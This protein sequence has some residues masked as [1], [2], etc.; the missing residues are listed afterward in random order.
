MATTPPVTPAPIHPSWFSKALTWVKHEASVVKNSVLWLANKE[1]AVA[2][3]IQK[4]AP[5]VEELSN[6]FVPG[7]GNIEQHVVD[8]YGVVASAVHAAGDAAAAN[9]VSV[10][11]DAAL[12]ADIK[13]VLP[14]ILKYLSPQASSAPPAK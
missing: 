6:L 8:V 11:L 4:I 9:G 12:I 3:G 13:A 14:A 10:T 5:T 7:L 1:P 2:A